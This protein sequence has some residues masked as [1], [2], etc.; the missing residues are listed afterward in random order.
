MGKK[1]RR[2]GRYT[3]PRNGLEADAEKRN[4]RVLKAFRDMDRDDSDSVAG[5]I[6]N[7]LRS[8]A[9]WFPS[10]E[11]VQPTHRAYILDPRIVRRE[12]KSGFE[13][14]YNFARARQR[15]EGQTENYIDEIPARLGRIVFLG[16]RHRIVGS[17]VQSAVMRDERASLYG[18]LADSG[19]RGFNKLA[20]AKVSTPP[21]VL[22]TLQA[23]LH[24]AAARKEIQESIETAFD[25]HHGVR[26][27]TFGELQITEE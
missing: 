4:P 25:V 13:A 3:P 6:R 14:G 5:V 27:V 26:N 1:Q 18:G 12:F 8:E 9:E 22:F 21:V 23:P 16:D 15:I 2:H 20:N 10:I 7:F 19:L 11:R 17:F 24:D